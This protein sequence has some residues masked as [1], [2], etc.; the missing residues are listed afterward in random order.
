VE[1]WRRLD[2]LVARGELTGEE[3]RVIRRITQRT[4]ADVEGLLARRA[5]GEMGPV[6]VLL[7]SIPVRVRHA[8]AVVD[9]LGF[10]RA[11]EVRAV[12]RSQE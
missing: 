9:E 10:A 7:R 8:A 5:A 1:V 11:R 2:D 12:W 4:F 3:A 6:G